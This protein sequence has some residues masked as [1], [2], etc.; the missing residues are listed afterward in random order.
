MKSGPCRD[1]DHRTV[2]CHGVCKDYQKW[3]EEDQAEKKWL[4]DQKY[5]PSEA[6]RKGERQS[7]RA[8]SRG[9]KKRRVKNYD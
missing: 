4:K 9:W 3:K 2:T 7:L 1:C 6:M 8:R 5:E